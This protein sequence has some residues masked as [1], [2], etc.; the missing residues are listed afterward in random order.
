MSLKVWMNGKLVDKEAATI[1]VYDHGLLYGDGIFEGIR[2]Y[3]G[4][5]FRLEAHVA[6][7]F[8]GA[9]HIMLEIPYTQQEIRNAIRETLAA[10]EFQDAYIR[11]VVTRGVGYLGLAPNQTSNPTTFIIT[12]QITM[13]PDEMYENGMP[14]ITST[15]CRNHTNAVPPQLKSCNY[16]NNILAQIDAMNAGV[17]EAIM[18]NVNGFVA[19]CTGD[20]IFLIKD[21]KV[22]TPSL[23]QG[24]LE[25]ITRSV[26][27][28][29]CAEMGMPVEESVVTR[30]DLYT[31]DEVFITG[32][33]AEVIGVSKIDDRVIGEGITGPITKQLMAAFGKL[34]R[35]E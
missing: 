23:D 15:I 33:A 18:L 27:I 6:R 16:L 35:S 22:R 1:N 12:D 7:L 19:E 5:P 4:E 3:G 30:H 25:G 28:E 32:T 24:I 11:P 17:P 13:Y 34:A 10:N 26:V 31:A 9:H 14:V 29:I 20:N 2:A 8:R 21:G